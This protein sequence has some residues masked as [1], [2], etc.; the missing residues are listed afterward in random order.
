MKGL[1]RGEFRRSLSAAERQV[2]K[3]DLVALLGWQTKLER[4]KKPRTRVDAVPYVALYAKGRLY[5]CFGA[6]E[7][8][9]DERL[10]R[11]FLSALEDKRFGLLPAP[12][13]GALAAEVSFVTRVAAIDPDAI[14]ASFEPGVHGLGVSRADGTAVILLPS[15]ARD[16]GL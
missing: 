10:A 8:A 11:A 7:G 9:P 12:M 15:V 14:E 13:R 16:H 6:E 1:Y 2:L 5:G 4:W 3:R